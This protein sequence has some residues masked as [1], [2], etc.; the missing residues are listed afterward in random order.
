MTGRTIKFI[1][2]HGFPLTQIVTENI[3]KSKIQIQYVLL[4][5]IMLKISRLRND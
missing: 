1:D 5:T 3:A 2:G 4:T